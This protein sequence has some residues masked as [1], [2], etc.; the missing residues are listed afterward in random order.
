MLT[1]KVVRNEKG[2]ITQVNGKIASTRLRSYRVPPAWE[3]IEVD[4]DPSASLIAIGYDS[5]GRKQYLYSREHAAAAKDDKFVKIR[6]M[7]EEHEEIRSQIEEDLNDPNVT[8]MKREAALV[9]Y[10][11][12]ETGIRPGS[13]QDTKGDVD[14]FGA[15]T[16][17]LRHLKNNDRSVRMSFIGKKGVQQNVLVTNPYL[18][19]E[20]RERKE[21]SKKW[22]QPVF[23][24][25]HNYLRNYVSQLGSGGYT[26]KDLRTMRGS[27][28]AMELVEQVKRIPKTKTDR[29]KKVNEI[30]D[31][32]ADKLG[33]TRAVTRSAY[34]DPEIYSH[35]EN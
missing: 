23:N 5:K 31:K 6:Q 32:V 25:N 22:S 10:L 29:K 9:A 35:L 13:D 3:N 8:D 1:A 21:A 19:E 15:T 30:L 28:F 26:T 4:P 20:L 24:M 17:Q 33:N 27:L 18:V 7:I 16:L 12:Y 14:A 11:I 34:V 2:L